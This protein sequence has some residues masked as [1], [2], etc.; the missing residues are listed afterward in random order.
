MTKMIKLGWTLR[1]LRISKFDAEQMNDNMLILKVW[2]TDKT[3]HIL[4]LSTARPNYDWHQLIYDAIID[5]NGCKTQ[6]N[7]VMFQAERCGEIEVEVLNII[8]K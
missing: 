8:C 2:Y 5:H 3:Q 7:K 6:Y 1:P 4:R